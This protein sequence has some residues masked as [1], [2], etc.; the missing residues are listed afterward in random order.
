MIGSHNHFV[1]LYRDDGE[2]ARNAGRFL[3]EGA[4]QGGCMIV[5][6]TPVHRDLLMEQLREAEIDVESFQTAG[7]LLCFDAEATLASL[8]VDG[9]PDPARFE[10]LISR[11]VR[12]MRVLAGKGGVRAFGEMVDLLW[13]DGRPDAALQLEGLWNRLLENEELSLFCSYAMDFLEVHGESLR[14]MLC[15][16]SH[17]LPAPENDELGR[18]LDRAMSDVFGSDKAAALLPL[19][20]ANQLPRVRIPQPAATVL[21][22][23]LNLP[24]YAGEILSRVRAYRREAVAQT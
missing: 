8:L 21:W 14:R 18:A 11:R 2:L 7:T 23:R 6:A 9:M 12:E 13:K 22:L 24:R 20:H 5:V 10:R 1:Q 3:R 15:S 17:L 16:H 4:V 19:I